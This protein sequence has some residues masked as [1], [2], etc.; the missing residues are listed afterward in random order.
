MEAEKKDQKVKSHWFLKNLLGAVVFL[1]GLMVLA[2]ILLGVFTHHGKNI[3]V[4]D[5]TNMSVA[6]AKHI[7]DSAGVR[8]Q[9]LDS[10]YVRRMAK[11]AVFSQSPKAGS[12]VKKG[13]RILLTT[14]AVV[15]KKVTMPNLVGYSMRQA[16]GILTARGLSVGRLIYVT[17]IA[18]NNVLQQQIRG[19]DI[20][21]GTQIDSGT[22][23]DLVL[24]LDPADNKTYVPKTIGMKYSR[25][26]DLI[27]DNSLN[28]RRLV[29]DDS[30]KNFSDS[31]NAVVY[32]QTPAASQAPV[33]MGSDVSLYLTVNLERL[34]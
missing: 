26:V 13:R 14:N 15:P 16:R 7:A 2:T 1:I 5:M 25:A 18:T 9:I 4:P 21:P 28:V 24:G 17:D 19:R 20:Q 10:V 6:Q 32:R 12:Q 3:E 31:L 30:V 22:D 11:G 33:I 8:I 29:F 34:P 23:I 27:N